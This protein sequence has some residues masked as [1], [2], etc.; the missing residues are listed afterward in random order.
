MLV[1]LGGASLAAWVYLAFF[2][3]RFW[4]ADQRLSGTPSPDVGA[5]PNGVPSVVAVVPARDEA[6]VIERSIASLLDQDYPGPF[7]VVLVDDHSDDDTAARAHAVAATHAH[8]DRLEVIRAADRPPGWVGKMWAVHSGVAR[9]LDGG[10]DGDADGASLPDFVL[11]TDA[12]VAHDPGNVRRL[13]AKAGGADENAG[14]EPLQLVSLMVLLHC[15][16][17]WERLLIPAFVY[18]FQKLYPFPLINDPSSR[19]AGA[20]GGCMLVRT[21]ALIRAGGIAAI[22]DRVI[23]DCALATAIKSRSGPIWVGV[24]ESEVS[25]RPYRGLHDIWHMVARSAYTQLHHSPLL[26]AGTVVGLLLIYVAPPALVLAW[27]FYAGADTMFADLVTAGGSPSLA[28]AAA[29]SGLAAWTLMACTF[30]PTLRMYGLAPVRAFLLPIAGILYL[31]MTID[32]ARLH[33]IGRGAT[34]KGRTGAGA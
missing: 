14:T 26:L 9:A 32:S 1:A 5:S 28:A 10:A 29:L 34:W 24:T 15:R 21:E 2:H 16:S 11:L 12:D 13:V 4:R 22:R 6:E 27:P 8:G 33:W 3:G 19:V 23:D 18:F 7:S 31:C 30:V 25:F 20:A 17:S